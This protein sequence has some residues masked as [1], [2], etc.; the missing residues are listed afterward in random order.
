MAAPPLTTTRNSSECA[1]I[2]L[3]PMVS[4]CESTGMMQ[5]RWQIQWSA[6]RGWGWSRTGLTMAD[7]ERSSSAQLAKALEATK[8][9]SDSMGRKRRA[10]R[11]SPSKNHGTET[12]RRRWRRGGADGVSGDFCCGLRW[13]SEWERG[14]NRRRGRHGRVTLPL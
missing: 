12:A 2:G 1:K 11:S 5:G 7:S 13:F 3:R 4:K 9:E 8:P 14:I 10:R 6:F